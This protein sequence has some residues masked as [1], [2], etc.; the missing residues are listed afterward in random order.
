MSKTKI[1]R[2][3]FVGAAGAAAATVTLLPSGHLLGAKAPS[4]RV[5]VAQIGAGGKGHSDCRLSEQAGGR[6]VAVCDVD[7]RRGGGTFR[8]YAKAKKYKDFR[9]LFDEMDK[10][11]DAV[12]V[13]TPDHMHARISLQAMAMGKGVYCQKPLTRTVAEARQMTEAAAK[14]KVAT[15]MGNQGHSTGGNQATAEYVQAGAIGTVR[16]VHVWTDRPV[17]WWPQGMGLPKEKMPVPPTLAWD[18]WLGVAPVRPYHKS[19]LPFVWRGWVGFGTGA[20]GDIACHAMDSP[21][22]VLGLTAP[23]SVK[24]SCSP[25]NGVSFPNWSIIEYQFPAV[26]SRAAVKLVWYD[27]GKKPPRP[28]QL[29]ADR[30]FG[31]NGVLYI[32]DKGAML[33]GGGGSFCRLIPEKRMK[34]FPAPKRTLPRPGGHYA[35]WIDACKGK[36]RNGRRVVPGSHFGYSGPMT[37]A[38]LLGNVALYYPGRELQWDPAKMAFA[39]NSD[40]NQYLKSEYR[41]G[42][43]L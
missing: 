22:T 1:T 42:W 32:G 37:E 9:R 21:F 15:Q 30:R 19:Y 35:D 4:N 13:S 28:L 33:G 17:K 5:N 3:R 38:V 26:D 34:T 6:I 16:E 12:V 7:T 36:M 10:D 24:A 31:G 40:A 43:T 25:F 20:L 39:N 29:E 41:K 23:T 11:V 14:Y 8:A 27:G 18:L 2:R